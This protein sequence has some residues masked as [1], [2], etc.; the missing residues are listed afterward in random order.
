MSPDKHGNEELQALLGGLCNGTLTDTEHARLQA[1]LK[2]DATAREEYLDYIDLHLDLKRIH[3]QAGDLP[4]NSDRVVK[5]ILETPQE[6]NRLPTIESEST[7]WKPMPHR[8]TKFQWAALAVVAAS[9]LFL[10]GTRSLGPIEP[11]N[12]AASNIGS[13]TQIGSVKPM[14]RVRLTQ[15]AST[16]FFGEPNPA[17]QSIVP[18]GHEYAL[19]EGMISLLFPAGATAIIES[20]AIFEISD[21]A[22]LLMKTGVCSVHAPDGAQG[23]RVDTPMANVVDLGTRFVLSVNQSGETKVQVIEGEADV[24]T[25]QLA[26][27]MKA[28]A[29]AAI[30]LRE[31]DARLIESEDRVTAR[32]IPFKGSDYKSTLPDRV[33]GF[34][35]VEDERGAVDELISVSFQRNGVETKYTVEQL[36]GIDMIYFNGTSNAFMVSSSD[37]DEPSVTDP[38][39]LS[40]ARFLDRDRRLCSGLINTGGQASPLTTDPVMNS[41][42]QPDAPGTPG[43]GFRFQTPVTN[44]VGPDV[45]LF[46]LQTIVNS[47]KGDAFHVSPLHFESGLHS[48]TIRRYDID[49]TSQQSK[50]LAPY[51]L[52]RC[53]QTPRSL[54]QANQ[55]PHFGGPIHGIPAKVITVGIDLSDLGYSIG[56]Q[57]EGLFLQD[58]ADDNDSFDPVFIAGLPATP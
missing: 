16:K 28:G 11:S 34:E 8:F 51:R 57:V 35:A 47:E 58:A 31:R 17:L 45:V 56:A 39:G 9:I 12:T 52:Y 40:R 53:K 4:L 20:P 15:V 19:S 7:G 46:E 37:V 49:M 25:K 1:I 27:D 36:I 41:L 26:S 48:Q 18:F 2:M 23:F 24:F 30:K 42:E 21:D 13:G 55:V 10:I 22:R 3:T 43:F 44:V 14:S 6:W 38:N 5:A 32:T 29:T 33:T 54:T 50:T